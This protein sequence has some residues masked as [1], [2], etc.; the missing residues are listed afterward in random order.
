MGQGDHLSNSRRVM[1][2]L[3]TTEVSPCPHRD[4]P[5]GHLGFG[6]LPPFLLL[7]LHF[8]GVEHVLFRRV[9]AI[10]KAYKHTPTIHCVLL[11]TT[12]CWMQGRPLEGKSSY[13]LTAVWGL[14]P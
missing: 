13:N 7:S 2:R 6:N 5:E 12:E 4:N 9:H 14:E 11:H 10:C 1:R 8:Y 3:V